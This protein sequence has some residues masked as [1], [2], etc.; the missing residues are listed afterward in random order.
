GPALQATLVPGTADQSVEKQ[1]NDLHVS[2]L[3]IGLFGDLTV[4]QPIYTFGKIA[5]RQEAAAHGVRARE[6]QTRMKSADVAFEVAQIYE[7]FLFA[8]DAERYLVETLHWLERTHE[9]AQERLDADAKGVSER[10]IL[11]LQSAEALAQIGVDQARAGMAQAKAGLAAY[12]GFPQS[13]P[14]AFAET[15]QDTVGRTPDSV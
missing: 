6:A 1:Y 3:S 4:I 8:R 5:N 7:G 12:L 11:R 10:D 15:E 14:I 2:D 9:A 13:E